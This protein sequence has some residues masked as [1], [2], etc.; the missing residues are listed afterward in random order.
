MAAGMPVARDDDGQLSRTE[1]LDRTIGRTDDCIAAGD[2]ER[3]AGQK[4]ELYVGNDEGV[5]AARGRISIRGRHR[6]LLLSDRMTQRRAW[7]GARRCSRGTTAS[8]VI[9][10][11]LDS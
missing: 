4:I 2:A 1:T 5:T 3:A 9:D 10:E 6:E 11:P 7:F 8:H